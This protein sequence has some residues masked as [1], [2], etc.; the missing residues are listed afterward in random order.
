LEQFDLGGVWLTEPLVNA[1]KL[2]LET[3][4]GGRK[5]SLCVDRWA[6]EIAT[7]LTVIICHC[8]IGN[9][10]F[11]LGLLQAEYWEAKNDGIGSL[12]VL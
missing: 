2:E 8:G 5:W 4:R 10:P 1:A 3:I 12:H 7:P 11:Y 6:A 9:G